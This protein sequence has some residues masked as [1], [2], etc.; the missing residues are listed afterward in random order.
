MD[1]V[2]DRRLGVRVATV[3]AALVLGCGGTQDG[4]TERP[5][6]ESQALELAIE[7][8]NEECMSKFSTAPFDRSSSR[9]V[10]KDGRWLWGGLDL[11]G[12]AGLSASVSFDAYGANRH[13]E[14]FLSTDRLQPSSP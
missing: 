1:L 13:V 8:A 12:P 2:H 9:I 11:A 6:S 5:I 3:C 7:I 10:F 4:G 14:V